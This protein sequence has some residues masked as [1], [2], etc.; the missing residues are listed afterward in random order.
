MGDSIGHQFSQGFEA[1]ALGRGHEWKRKVHMRYNNGKKQFDCLATSAPIRGGGA[2]GFWR[3]TKLLERSR[4]AKIMPCFSMERKWGENFLHM[5]LDY[6]YSELPADVPN[7][8]KHTISGFDAVVVRLPHGW[9]KVH[10]LT[11]ERIKEAVIFCQEMLGARVVVFTTVGLDNNAITSEQWE[12]VTKVNEHLHD[13]ARNWK[14]PRD[15]EAGVEWVLVQEFSNFTSTLL[16][17]N[18]KYI[19][20]KEM[21]QILAFV[22]YGFVSRTCYQSPKAMMLARMISSSNGW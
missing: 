5:L 18:G 15:G 6:E 1:A 14:P 11:K 4:W 21:L 8:Q 12:G 16:H 2:T 9:M 20:E 3:Y 10:E 7:Q 17:E 13:V 19:G 22:S